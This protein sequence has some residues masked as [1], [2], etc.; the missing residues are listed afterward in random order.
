MADDQPIGGPSVLVASGEV[1][2]RAEMAVAFVVEGAVVIDAAHAREALER[3]VRLRP[4][5]LVVDLSEAFGGLALLEEAQRRGLTDD[6][7]VVGLAHPEDPAALAEAHLLGV[8]HHL[9]VPASID[10]IVATALD[11]WSVADRNEAPPTA[12][13]PPAEVG[14]VTYPEV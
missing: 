2:A 7:R 11:G 8:E 1:R 13:T 14:P 6:L 5:V 12:G 10:E 4:S 3:L 9:M